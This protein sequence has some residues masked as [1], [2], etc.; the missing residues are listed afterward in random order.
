MQSVFAVSIAFIYNKLL[1]LEHCL[2]PLIIFCVN[3]VW[4]ILEM[5]YF[6]HLNKGPHFRGCSMTHV[7]NYHDCNESIT[8]NKKNWNFALLM[9]PKKLKRPKSHRWHIFCNIWDNIIF[10]VIIW[11]Q[12]T[13]LKRR[14]TYIWEKMF[15]GT[16][17]NRSNVSF[18]NALLKN[19]IKYTEKQ[20]RSPLQVLSHELCQTF[21][22]S[23]FT[24]HL[25]TVGGSS[26]GRVKFC[27]SKI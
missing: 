22:N 13:E 15:P 14:C 12:K 3:S 1:N 17:S 16:I 6:G 21:Q 11:Q 9:S 4:G 5:W 26:G 18:K 23:N 19:F 10:N 20:N 7:M 2:G 25:W 27:I 8:K 24:E